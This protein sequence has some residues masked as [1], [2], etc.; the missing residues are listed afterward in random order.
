MFSL[1][2]NDDQNDL[3]DPELVAR[4]AAEA[5]APR[6]LE[7]YT[8]AIHTLHEKKFTFREIA[9]WLEE[10]FGIRADHNSVWRVYTKTMDDYEAHL[11]AEADDEIERDEAWAEAERD[12]TLITTSP[13][14]VPTADVPQRAPATVKAAKAAPK[15]GRKQNRKAGRR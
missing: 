2:M 5:V 9:K 3:P 7:D 1:K 11:V 4:A 15:K 6:V 8:V 14:A 10:K 12:G 13:K